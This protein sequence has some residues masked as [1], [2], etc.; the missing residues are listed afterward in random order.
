MQG[1]CGTGSTTRSGGAKHRKIRPPAML[2]PSGPP[3]RA[4]D[5]VPHRPN[6]YLSLQAYPF[7]RNQV[8]ARPNAS[9]TGTVFHPNSRSALPQDT[10]IFLRPIRTASMVARGSRLR[11]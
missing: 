2:R 11:M 10:N 6:R 3:D 8:T 7:A 4:R 5:P 1:F 9:S